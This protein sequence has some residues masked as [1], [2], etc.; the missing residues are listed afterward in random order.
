M[1]EIWKDVER[2]YADVVQSP[3]ACSLVLGC[4]TYGRWSNDAARLI[5]ELAALKAAQAP[6]MLRRCANLAWFNRWWALVGVGVHRAIAE[7]LLRQAGADLH[8]SVPTLEAL[9]LGDVLLAQR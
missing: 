7:S 4:E 6:P 8:S 5:R 1:D 2:T 3:Q 9:P